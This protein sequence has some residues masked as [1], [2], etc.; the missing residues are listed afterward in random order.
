MGKRKK[1]KVVLVCSR[2]HCV[3]EERGY[4][5]CPRCGKPHHS[6]EGYKY[7]TAER[8]NRKRLGK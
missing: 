8:L 7:K 5:K 3:H 4:K 1:K 2:C 6:S